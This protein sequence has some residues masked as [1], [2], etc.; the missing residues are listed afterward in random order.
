M[1]NIVIKGY[2]GKSSDLK[3]MF[4]NNALFVFSLFRITE[5]Q[6]APLSGFT[7]WKYRYQKYTKKTDYVQADGW[8]VW[9]VQARLWCIFCIPDC[10]SSR[11]CTVTCGFS[12]R[13]LLYCDI[14]VRIDSI[15]NICTFLKFHVCLYIA[16]V[17]NHIKEWY[18][19]D[20]DAYLPCL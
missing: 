10:T 8:S 5:N 7:Y 4:H 13:F 16:R 9:I 3:S 12:M 11:M 18:V 19:Y 20:Y 2:L 15:W 6:W 17:K 14:M 1:D